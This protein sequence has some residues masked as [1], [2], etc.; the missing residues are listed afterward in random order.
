MDQAR[1]RPAVVRGGKRRDRN[2]VRADGA[3][4]V[5]PRL[6]LPSRLRGPYDRDQHP[7][8]G[9]DHRASR[10]CAGTRRS[11]GGDTRADR[12]AAARS[13]CGVHD[14]YWLTARRHRCRTRLRSPQQPRRR[15]RHRIRD[16][17]ARRRGLRG[18]VLRSRLPRRRSRRHL[19]LLVRRHQVRP[20]VSLA[21]RLP[22][23]FLARDPVVHSDA[24]HA[25]PR[26]SRPRTRQ[27]AHA[28]PPH[29][30]ADTTPHLGVV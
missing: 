28:T 23:P 17:H 7:G 30:L 1:P 21:H 2:A 18:G 4:S 29:L 25:A 11:R 10:A 15:R 22:L 5:S 9:E 20:A 26:S 13:G 24:Q 19:A 12:G 6:R 27:H 3:R 8:H 14:A 16:R